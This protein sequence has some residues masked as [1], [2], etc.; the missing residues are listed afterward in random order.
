MAE[1]S[2]AADVHH[3]S[4]RAAP[5]AVS[6][7]ADLGAVFLAVGWGLEGRVGEYQVVGSGLEDRAGE[8]LAADSS[9]YPAS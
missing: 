7:V 3:R 1:A 4:G 8:Y 2:R 9:R 6:H 5:A